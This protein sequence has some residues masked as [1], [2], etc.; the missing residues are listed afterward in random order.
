M[1]RPAIPT[2]TP[3]TSQLPEL[4]NPAAWPDL[5]VDFWTWTTGDGYQNEVQIADYG[6]AAMDYIDT[7]LAGSDTLID[8]VARSVKLN[9][10]GENE[11]SLDFNALT[12]S[13]FYADDA[14]TTTGSPILPN[15]GVSLLHNQW[16][17]IGF[18]QLAQRIS[19][20]NPTVYS[21]AKSLSGALG[22]WFQQYGQNNVLGTV[23]EISGVPSGALIETGT[24]ANGTYLRFANGTQFCFFGL[25]SSATVQQVWTFPAAFTGSPQTVHMT[26][27]AI[28]SAA[29]GISLLSSTSV[30]FAVWD[31][32]DAR[33]AAFTRITA[34]GR[35]F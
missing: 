27:V 26:P 6:E 17:S 3:Y 21:R 31:S 33:V 19:S 34:I 30:S 24:N 16:D 5:S 10:D 29:P 8:A 20:S 13:G 4:Q 1:A 2:L 12:R 25:D 23:A 28:A 15:D 32:A 35:W 22:R 11:V 18:S 14:G 7:A 9:A